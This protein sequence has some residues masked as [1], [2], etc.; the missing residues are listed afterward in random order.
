MKNS[1]LLFFIAPSAIL[2]ILYIWFRIKGQFQNKTT[3]SARPDNEY[4]PTAVISNDN[5]ILVTNASAGELDLVITGF[6]NMYNKQ[7][8]LVLPRVYQLSDKQ[9]AITFPYDIGLEVFCYMI[10][11]LCYPIELDRPL[12]AIGWTTISGATALINDEYTGKQAMVY[13]SDTDA[14]ADNVYI[15]TYNNVCVKQS[16]SATSSTQFIDPPVKAFQL[17]AVDVKEIATNKKFK[18]YK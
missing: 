17:P 1:Q 3:A 5:L 6:C 7:E 15:T 18:D 9:F 12:Q 11:Y 16:F 4:L 8:F 14:E 13:I 2:I 10:N